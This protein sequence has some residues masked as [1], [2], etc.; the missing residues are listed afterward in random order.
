MYK[1]HDGVWRLKISSSFNISYNTTTKRDLSACQCALLYLCS[2]L[3][4]KN[5]S[6]NSHSR[7]EVLVGITDIT[8][9][10]VTDPVCCW[11]HLVL[12]LGVFS[13]SH[14]TSNCHFTMYLKQFHYNKIKNSVVLA[15]K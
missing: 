9:Y 3:H 15:R 6:Y 7:R 4:L 8:E 1:A 2:T 12:H 14:K 13:F 5:I 10:L 11:I